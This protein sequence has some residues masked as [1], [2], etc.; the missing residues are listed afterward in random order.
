[1]R[2]FV[3]YDIAHPKRLRRVAKTM[4]D[5]G[6]R[7]QKSKFEMTLSGTRLKELQQR[8]DEIIEP[9]E[10]GV[11]YFPLCQKCRVKL[12]I[13]GQGCYIDPDTEYEII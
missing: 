12:E 7:V 9:D 2:Y 10:D 1:M 5:Y 11:K 4:E 8:I 3:V 13:I 6:K